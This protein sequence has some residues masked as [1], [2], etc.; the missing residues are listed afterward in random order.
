M[1]SGNDIAGGEKAPPQDKNELRRAGTDAQHQRTKPDKGRAVESKGPVRLSAQRTAALLAKFDAAIQRRSEES[2]QVGRISLGQKQQLRERL[3]QMLD[4]PGTKLFA[5]HAWAILGSETYLAAADNFKDFCREFLDTEVD[6]LC[7]LAGR[8]D[9]DRGLDPFS[10][11]GAQAGKHVDPA[12]AGV[13]REGT[14]TK[15]DQ[16]AAE[17]GSGHSPPTQV[18]PQWISLSSIT[19]D[20]AIQCRTKVDMPTV[21]KYAEAMRQRANFPPI[22]VYKIGAIYLLAA[23]WHRYHARKQA[24]WSEIWAE[25]RIGTRKDAV[26]CALQADHDHGLPLSNRDKRRLV[27]VALREFPRNADGLIAEHCRVSA[28][29]VG[30]IRRELK[31]VSSS[32][33]RTGR[34]GKTRKMPKPRAG[35]TSNSSSTAGD[36]AKSAAGRPSSASGA[37]ETAGD[38]FT[39]GQ[40][41]G[42]IEAFLLP[43][44]ETCKP[45]LRMTLCE[46]LRK[47]ADRQLALIPP[48]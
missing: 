32:E 13:T 48:E 41:W 24:G 15:D 39:P 4:N 10:L 9:E 11:P 6:D 7:D 36:G 14:P 40:E 12:A 30:K 45:Q 17:P 22:I 19:L 44:F 3:V 16:P 25:I 47:F 27:E 31:T 18:V 28:P 2:I 37:K 43:R 21:A 42:S 46:N 34:D 33:P 38:E 29:F 8:F 5:Q 1:F 20:P 26:R 35:G 23:G